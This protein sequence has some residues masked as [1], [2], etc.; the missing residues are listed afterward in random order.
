MAFFIS[1][2]GTLLFK[3][4]PVLTNVIKKDFLIPRQAS[5]I[6]DFGQ[7]VKCMGN[8]DQADSCIGQNVLYVLYLS[9][10]NL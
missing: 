3:N 7:I 10:G 5:P 8:I 6:V 2:T 9:N 1:V 4:A